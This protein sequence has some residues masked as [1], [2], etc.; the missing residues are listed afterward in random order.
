MSRVRRAHAD[1]HVQLT[2]VRVGPV[3]ADLSCRLAVPSGATRL[4]ILCCVC[5]CQ[6]ESVTHDCTSTSC[7]APNDCGETVVSGLCTVDLDHRALLN[8][9][10]RVILRD[11][12]DVVCMYTCSMWRG[13]LHTRR[14]RIG[15]IY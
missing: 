14:G 1:N 6:C 9:A 4:L 3:S 10:I 11:L 15:L 7:R 13:V 5:V 12:F 8:I 2:C